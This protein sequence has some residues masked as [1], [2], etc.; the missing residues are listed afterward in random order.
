MAAASCAPQGTTST[1]GAP[2]S[3]A[4]STVAPI[5][6]SLPGPNEVWIFDIA[7]MPSTITINAGETVTWVNHDDFPY[8]IV[9]VDGLFQSPE[10]VWGSIW[11]FTFKEPGTYPYGI[12]EDVNSVEGFVV[13]K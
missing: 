13:V 11:S 9:S 4:P 8:T 3:A 6:G 10:M 1:T 5:L 2:S 7:L 12:S